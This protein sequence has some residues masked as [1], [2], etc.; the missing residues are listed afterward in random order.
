MSGQEMTDELS[1]II[2]KGGLQKLFPKNNAELYSWNV[3]I[4][5]GE[6][7]LKDFNSKT[8]TDSEFECLRNYHFKNQ[9]LMKLH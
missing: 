4:D 7:C 1:K 3:K 2:Y 8:L 6:Y 5:A 9:V